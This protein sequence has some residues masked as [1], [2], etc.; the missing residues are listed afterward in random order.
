[1]AVVLGTANARG[2][3]RA[4]KAQSIELELAQV[5]ERLEKLRHRM[6]SALG[7]GTATMLSIAAATLVVIAVL[8][9]LSFIG[10]DGGTGLLLG[11]A[12]TVGVPLT[13]VAAIG[14]GRPWWRMSHEAAMLRQREKELHTERGDS[15]VAGEPVLGDEYFAMAETEHPV[16]YRARRPAR[17]DA[18][19]EVSTVDSSSVATI[20]DSVPLPLAEYSALSAASHVLGRA[21]RST[22]TTDVSTEPTPG[23]RGSASGSHSG[24]VALAEVIED[25]P[26]EVDTAPP[27]SS[28]QLVQ[29]TR[30]AQ[31]ALR[32]SPANPTWW[33]P[34]GRNRKAIPHPAA[35]DV[36]QPK[37][38]GWGL[39]LV[40]GALLAL[41]AVGVI[42][43]V[44]TSS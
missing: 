37:I 15:I 2:R 1:M 33:A 26:V 20:A 41:F 4:S 3:H 32:M 28:G 30:P 43:G 38:G 10:G 34:H 31:P 36:A 12:F 35:P 14:V 22:L 42:F 25:T 40:G 21:V 29:V 17:Y 44:L 23:E 9:F 5:R 13:A 24:A 27:K 16:S 7:V 18:L 39:L 11:G 6:R 19:D 8:A